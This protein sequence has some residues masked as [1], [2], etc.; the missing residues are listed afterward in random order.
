MSGIRTPSPVPEALPETVAPGAALLDAIEVGTS[1]RR[2]HAPR[3]E[4]QERIGIGG[5]A[6]VDLCRDDR[7]GRLVARKALRPELSGTH[8]FQRRFE[9]EIQIQ[10]QLDH[11]AIVPVF[12]RGQAADGRT[13]FT[14]RRIG[15]ETLGVAIRRLAA[16]S[17]EERARERSRLLRAFL[18]VCLAVD[19]AHHRGVVH[20]DLKP[21]NLMLGLFGEVYVL[22]WGIAKVGSEPSD[23]VEPLESPLEVGPAAAPLTVAWRQ[24]G[25]PSYMSP[26]QFLDSSAVTP[27]SD[28]YSL[29]AVLF[30]LLTGQRFRSQSS[31]ELRAS[32]GAPWPQDGELEPS[33][34]APEAAIAPEYDAVCRRAC[35][36]DPEQRY[37]TARALHDAVEAALRGD[38]D[39]ALRRELASG[40]LEVAREHARVP[41]AE[42][43]VLREAGRALALDPANDEAAGLLTRYLLAPAQDDPVPLQEERDQTDL[44]DGRRM[45]RLNAIVSVVVLAVIGLLAVVTPIA[46]WG[47]FAASIVPAVLGTAVL[48]TSRGGVGQSVD[49][50]VRSLLVSLGF[51]LPIAFSATAF[52]PWVLPP[53]VTCVVCVVVAGVVAIG[54]RRAMVTSFAVC[55]L[56]ATQVLYAR[57]GP[58]YG[59][60]VAVDRVSIGAS[61]LAFDPEHTPWVV[62]I[63]ALVLVVCATAV[64]W[65]NS[66]RLLESRQQLHRYEWRLR[67]ITSAPHD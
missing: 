67:Q 21:G 55:T 6:E 20:R 45:L 19:Y 9:R 35:A 43:Q 25:T 7:L 56:L 24:L 48:A 38:R 22:D 60:E 37:P 16:C 12:D 51:S 66:D 31:Q 10:A 62:S 14:M 57:F 41:G 27:Q 3:Y 33:R 46:R 34:R 40:H 18:Q 5:M 30:E 13:F 53:L 4:L 61:M 36:P 17:P 1:F 63:L 44:A 11:P 8:V 39:L 15:G 50:V 28:V 58:S 65:R 49:R 23:G 26:E 64:V 2:R 47:L 32:H 52:G 29:G 54:W 42:A 59:F